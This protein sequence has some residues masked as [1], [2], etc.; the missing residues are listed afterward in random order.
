MECKCE[1]NAFR[2][3][4]P[5]R[6]VLDIIANKWTV[7]VLHVINAGVVRYSELQRKIP[8]ISQKVLTGVLRELEEN[9]IITRTI[10]PVV[11]PKV[12]YEITQLGRTLVV[13]LEALQIWAENHIP[14]VHA[15]REVYKKKYATVVRP[16]K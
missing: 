15:A 11:P 5:S 4:C 6:E 14:Q 13:T 9:G 12:E 8:G 3:G 7:L 2:S 16:G 1:Y 10:Y